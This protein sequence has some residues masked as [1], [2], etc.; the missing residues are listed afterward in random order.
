[1]QLRAFADVRVAPDDRAIDDRAD[2]DGDVV[3]QDGR[4]DDLDVRADLH[5]LAEEDGA[6]EPRGFVDV[7][8]A[9]RPDARHELVPEA[10]AFH[11]P[12]EEVG[13]RAPVLGDGA[14]V[15]PVT[16]GDV[17]EQGL[18]LGEQAWEQVL[19]EIEDVADFEALHHAWLDDVDAGVDRIAEDLAPGRLLE[20]FRDPPVLAGD[21]D[22]V[23]EWIR[24]VDEGERHRRAPLAVERDDLRQIDVRER[25]A[26]DDQERAIEIRGELPHRAARAERRLLDA[27][28]QAHPNAP[29][30]AVAVLD[31]R[32][33]VLEGDEGLLDPVALEELE[34]V[35]EAR[36][37]DDG[38]HWLGTVDRQR[39][40][41]AP[42]A[43]RH[44]D[45]LHRPESSWRACASGKP[46]DRQPA[47]RRDRRSRA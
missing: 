21:H 4:S 24:D 39:S 14:D 33:E 45:G 18:A 38:H 25:V 22:A 41:T 19:A 27:V 16:V 43:A 28:A 44:D 37:V 11:L 29:A 1:M 30:V 47:P 36:L 15:G 26:R 40:K 2:I 23:F 7:D 34:D 13:V 31:D 8:V 46:L 35:P 9:R 10:L 42:L 3:A 6:G 12:A 17:A 20:E 32:G 5:A